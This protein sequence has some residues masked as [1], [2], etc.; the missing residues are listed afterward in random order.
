MIDV[1]HIKAIIAETD[2][3]PTKEQQKKALDKEI[4]DM[5]LEIKSSYPEAEFA[6]GNV[7]NL[8]SQNEDEKEKILELQLEYQKKYSEYQKF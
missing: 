3:R 6:E 2:S 1:E 4:H 8:T 7:L 5:E